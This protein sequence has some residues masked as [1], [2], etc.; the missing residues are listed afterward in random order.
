MAALLA[1]AKPCPIFNRVH[2][3]RA[4][5]VPPRGMGSR[6]LRAGI[7]TGRAALRTVPRPPVNFFASS[8]AV[9]LFFACCNGLIHGLPH[10]C[11]SSATVLCDYLSYSSPTSFTYCLQR[12]LLAARQKQEDRRCQTVG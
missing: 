9:F 5:G 3:W 8:S 12:R 7:V 1:L 11:R 2:R 6:S 4:G 10:A